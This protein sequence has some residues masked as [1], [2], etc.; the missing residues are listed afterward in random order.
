MSFN[1]STLLPEKPNSIISLLIESDNSPSADFR[2][3]PPEGNI[4][5]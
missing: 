3:I 4:K 1:T 2:T 5:G